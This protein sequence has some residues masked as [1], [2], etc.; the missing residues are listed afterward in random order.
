MSSGWN[1]HWSFNCT[2]GRTFRSRTRAV[3]HVTVPHNDGKP[4][5]IQGIS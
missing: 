5:R 1:A 2:C 3:A 4:H